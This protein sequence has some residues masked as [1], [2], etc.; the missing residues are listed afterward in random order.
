MLLQHRRHTHNLLLAEVHSRCGG[1]QPL[2][3]QQARL[4]GGDA[5][6]RPA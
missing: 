3:N 6:K 1:I 5:G 4:D 2:I